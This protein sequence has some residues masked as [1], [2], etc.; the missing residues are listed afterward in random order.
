MVPACCRNSI[1]SVLGLSSHHVLSLKF[2]RLYAPS[3]FV[4]NIG[5]TKLINASTLLLLSIHTA[6]SCASGIHAYFLTNRIASL[7]LKRSE[8]EYVVSCLQSSCSVFTC[9]SN[10]HK[11]LISVCRNGR[12]AEKGDS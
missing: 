4:P 7:E 11:K 5:P 9:G 1:V 2:V 8:F 12:S 3:L 6:A 10:I